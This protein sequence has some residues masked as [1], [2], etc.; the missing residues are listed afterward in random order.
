MINFE[1][2]IN[3]GRE[4]L[5]WYRVQILSKFVTQFEEGDMRMGRQTD[6]Y[7]LQVFLSILYK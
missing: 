6:R 4:Y 1:A 7:G 5:F 3:F 2:R